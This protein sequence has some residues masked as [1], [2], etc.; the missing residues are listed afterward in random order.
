MVGAVA[1][2]ATTVILSAKLCDPTFYFISI[3]LTSFKFNFPLLDTE[4][5]LTVHVTNPNVVSIQ[6][7]S[8]KMFIYYAGSLLDSTPVMAS[9]QPPRSCQLL[10]LSVRLSGLRLAHHA[11]RFLAYAALAIG[12]RNPP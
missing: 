7:S 3:D 11:T 5:I 1:A 8:T 9:S 4:M 6:Y 12:G 2:T 10:R